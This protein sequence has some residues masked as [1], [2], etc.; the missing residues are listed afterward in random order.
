[1]PPQNKRVED[2][3]IYVHGCSRGINMMLWVFG[4]SAVLCVCH[5]VMILH[6][7][8]KLSGTL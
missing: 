6:Q 4:D 8:P 3:E 1:M 7:N 5:M 2:L